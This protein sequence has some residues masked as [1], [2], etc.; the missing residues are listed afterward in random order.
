MKTGRKPHAIPRVG[1]KVYLPEDLALEVRL[2]L[3]DPLR[4]K[5][6]YGSVST[7]MERLVREWLSAASSGEKGH[8]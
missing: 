2:R 8:Q 5:V 6:R 4:D 1:F 7:L 3:T